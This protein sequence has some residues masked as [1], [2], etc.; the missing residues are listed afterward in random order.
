MIWNEPSAPAVLG[1]TRT[2][3]DLRCDTK[4]WSVW[5]EEEACFAS[6]VIMD[7][8]LNET[9]HMVT[10]EK[11]ENS[12]RRDYGYKRPTAGASNESVSNR[13]DDSNRKGSEQK[14]R[15]RDFTSET[16]SASS[17]RRPRSAHIRRGT[18]TRGVMSE[19]KRYVRNVMM[20]RVGSYYCH[21]KN[22]GQGRIA[23]RIWF[24]TRHGIICQNDVR[25]LLMAG[26]RETFCRVV[27][28][29]R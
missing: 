11:S 7:S 14:S 20:G 1:P 8:L 25:K 23:C 22:V 26:Q 6:V 19:C 5:I 2:D 13:I 10:V 3:N 29:R 18:E 12:A 9:N 4:S 27:L 21:R 15:Y 24:S 28:H 16:R 17:Y